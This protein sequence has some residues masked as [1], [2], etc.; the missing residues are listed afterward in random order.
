MKWPRLMPRSLFGRNV[1]LIVGLILLAEFGIGLAFYHWVQKP[2]LE[3]MV[4]FTRTYVHTVEHAAATMDATT[5]QRYA[6]DLASSGP[7]RLVQGAAPATFA[8]A[9]RYQLR[10]FLAQL[11]ATLGDTYA[12]GWEAGAQPRL[13]IGLNLGGTPWWLGIDASGFVGNAGQLLL[14][15]MVFAGLLAALG[16]AMIQRHIN[17]PLD[18][19]AEA[20]DELAH[21]RYPA[22]DM[23]HAP[24]EIARL[25]ERFRHMA[26]TRAATEHER[27]IML[28]G[29]SHD[30]RTPLAKLRLAVEMLSGADDRDLAQSM[31]RNIAAAD[32]VIDQFI[33]FARF[34]Q[35]EA[36]SVCEAGELIHSVAEL[37]D[38]PRVIVAPLPT[39]P[40]LEC[41]P[42]ALRRALTNLVEN[43]LRYSR[44]SVT[45]DARYDGR[46]LLVRVTDCGP[47]I[48]DDALERIRQ[49]FMRLEHARSG[50]PG[51]G[52]GLA[53]V[54][55]VAQLHRGRL[56]LHN[57]PRGGLEATLELP[58]KQG[59]PIPVT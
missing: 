47:G 58:V 57:R 34:G 25:A 59:K 16:A 28:A 31:V 2:R 48:A 22:L 41:R 14:G 45:I 50:P 20:A 42:V 19:L 29:I 3:R 6:I 44:D 30:L 7:V 54:E 53:I 1:L 11:H 18:A 5:R 38:T 55:R 36:E 9:E 46:A 26:N 49:P 23:P 52:L 39:L 8:P 24:L 33:D 37:A 27:E 56:Y 21:G 13:W 43:A 35:G 17:R 12:L 32:A 15:I 40:M 51:A 10:R 4:E